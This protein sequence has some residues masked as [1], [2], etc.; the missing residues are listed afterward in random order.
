M[1][2]VEH[3]EHR[4]ATNVLYTQASDRDHERMLLVQVEFQKIPL[5][6]SHLLESL[7]HSDF[8]N[9]K[10]TNHCLHFLANFGVCMSVH[11]QE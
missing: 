7:N 10:E 2:Y 4:A 5:Q 11:L 6:G 8:L 9:Y 1:S 3:S